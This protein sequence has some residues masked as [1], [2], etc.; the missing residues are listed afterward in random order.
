LGIRWCRSGRDGLVSVSRTRA[1]RSSSDSL[2]A[3]LGG[4]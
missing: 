3:W 1:S 2:V 4:V